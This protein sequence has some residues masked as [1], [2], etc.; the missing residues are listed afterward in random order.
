MFRKITI[1]I[2][3]VIGFSRNAFC[4]VDLFSIE[5]NFIGVQYNRA[6]ALKQYQIEI[7]NLEN[8]ANNRAAFIENVDAYCIDLN[9]TINNA[10]N[11]FVE[12][13]AGYTKKTDDSGSGATR[14]EISQKVF[15]GSVNFG[16]FIDVN[17]NIYPYLSF[18]VGLARLKNALAV[19]DLGSAAIYDFSVDGDDATTVIPEINYEFGIVFATEDAIFTASYN[20]KMLYDVDFTNVSIRNISGS[21]TDFAN[22]N[23]RYNIH[24]FS[25]GFRVPF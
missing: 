14:V 15:D 3:I 1:L 9:Y 22:F 13:K 6:F 12:F 17:S 24:N 8:P 5:G 4:N 23:S 7:Y 20:A 16:A 19:F 25:I 18:G 11:F 2:L 10:D 21:A